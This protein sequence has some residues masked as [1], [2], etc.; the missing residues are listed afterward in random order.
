MVALGCALT[1]GSKIGLRLAATPDA[2]GMLDL[3][4]SGSKSKSS[5]SDSHAFN[6]DIQKAVLDLK[7]A[8][9]EKVPGKIPEASFWSRWVG[10]C[11]PRSKRW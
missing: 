11:S 5:A 1:E 3:V 2:F 8:S 7:K 9:W 6:L 10:L 4:T